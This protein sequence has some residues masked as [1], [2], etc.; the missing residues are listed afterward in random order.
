VRRTCSVFDRLL[1]FEPTTS[2]GDATCGAIR[3]GPA[4]RQKRVSP[5]YPRSRW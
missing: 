3:D 1:A 2:G 4:T 5:S